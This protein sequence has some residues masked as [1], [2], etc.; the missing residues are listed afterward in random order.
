MPQLKSLTSPTPKKTIAAY[1]NIAVIYLG[2][3][4]ELGLTDKVIGNSLHPYTRALLT[5]IPEPNP[6]NRLKIREIPIRGEVPSAAEIPSGCRFHPRCPYAKDICIKNEP[7]L[8]EV[9]P[10]HYVACWRCSKR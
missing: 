4:V 9:E 1:E 6:E 5:A 8:I 10:D 3:I 7:P 2:K